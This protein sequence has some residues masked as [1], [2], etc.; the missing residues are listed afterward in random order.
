MTAQ[1]CAQ[2]FCGLRYS[3]P[4]NEA[5]VPLVIAATRAVGLILNGN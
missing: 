4:L 3:P 2:F 5:Y 1:I